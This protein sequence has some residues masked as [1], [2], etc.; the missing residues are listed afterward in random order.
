MTQDE[1]IEMARFA[2]IRIDSFGFQGGFIEEFEAFAALVAAKAI[3][4][5]ESQE[6]VAIVTG[7]AWETDIRFL[8]EGMALPPDTKL[9]THQPQRTWQ[10]LMDDERLQVINAN[11]SKGLWLMAKDIET[12]LK[13]KNG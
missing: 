2:G 3:A 9:Y 8:P 5:L 10:G 4:E 6:P 13:D 7:D 11:A 1:I 12:K